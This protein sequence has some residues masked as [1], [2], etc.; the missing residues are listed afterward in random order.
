LHAGNVPVRI[1]KE[2]PPAP[3]RAGSEAGPSGPA[4]VF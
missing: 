2:T 3:W 1:V 4:S